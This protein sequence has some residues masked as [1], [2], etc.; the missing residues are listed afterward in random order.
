MASASIGRRG[1]CERIG[2][3]R[4]WTVGNNRAKGIQ[5]PLLRAEAA[6]CTLC[7]LPDSSDHWIR[8][9][10]H[11]GMAECR[12]D[13]N[14]NIQDWTDQVEPEAKDLAKT[15]SNLSR[16]EDGYRVSIGNWPL[17]LFIKLLACPSIPP[18]ALARATLKAFA[19]LALGKIFQLWQIR[20]GLHGRA[21]PTPITFSSKKPWFYAV[22]VG[23]E[24]G[25][26][27]SA[28]ESAKHTHKF[29]GAQHKRFR[30]REEAQTYLDTPLPPTRTPW[31][32]G[33]LTIYT[34]GSFLK[35]IHKAGWGYVVVTPVPE[36]AIPTLA[37]QIHSDFG[38]LCIDRTSSAYGGAEVHTNNT[39]ELTALLEALR[40]L[41][42]PPQLAVL[43][44]TVRVVT[45]SQ[46]VLNLTREN[47]F[48]TVNRTLVL[49]CQHILRT[50][51][52]LYPTSIDW[53]KAHTTLSDADSFWNNEA[54]R[55][56]NAGV[57]RV[58][59]PLPLEPVPAESATDSLVGVSP[60]SLALPITA[61]SVTPSP[62]PTCAATF[63]TCAPAVSVSL[64]TDSS[65][66][67][68]PTC[69]SLTPVIILCPSSPCDAQH[70]AEADYG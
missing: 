26:F 48:P 21:V 10:Q 43:I 66:P 25:I 4:H 65:A 11:E 70:P 61:L 46:Y 5:D 58:G 13:F 24:T 62:D 18:E 47:W 33:Q 7:G 64:S 19:A 49:T 12:L 60:V 69:S 44:K 42:T 51:S 9:C 50:T 41:S 59:K 55:L 2:H 54:D 16:G 56:A 17:S 27:Q 8:E 6:R 22:R 23:G 3:E 37:N 68:L 53:I 36:D 29:T 31:C 28:S 40:W 32:E 34:D 1:L 45:D 15:L 57:H 38:R 35:S 14:N 20:S 30:S 67:P 52:A 63:P 39:G